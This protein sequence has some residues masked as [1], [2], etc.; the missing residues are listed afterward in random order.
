MRNAQ[1]KAEQ[2]GEEVLGKQKYLTVAEAAAYLR[3]R[4]ENIYRLIGEGRVPAFEPPFGK[5]LLPRAALDAYLKHYRVKADTP[6]K[7]RTAVEARLARLAEAKAAKANAQAE[8]REV[9]S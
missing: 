6:C 1:K 7:H 8:V 2:A 4:R 5:R 9:A 3:T